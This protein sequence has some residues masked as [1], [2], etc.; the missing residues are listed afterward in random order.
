MGCTKPLPCTACKESDLTSRV[1]ALLSSSPLKELTYLVV[2][3]RMALVQLSERK[4]QQLTTLT[5]LQLR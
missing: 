1:L 2:R 3:R 4:K 5:K